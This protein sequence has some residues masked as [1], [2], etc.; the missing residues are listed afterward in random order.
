MASETAPRDS[1]IV[2][3]MT[4]VSGEASRMRRV[5]SIPSIP[6]I[7][8]SMNTT[9]G[10]SSRARSTAS[11]PVPASP[12]TTHGVLRHL[13]R[14]AQPLARDRVVIDDQAR[15]VGMAFSS[16]RG[17]GKYRGDQA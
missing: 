6:G 1:S 4:F 5:A 17:A 7:R 16:V 13:Q 14:G 8:T 3:R 2:M 12:T 11:S 9:S 10:T 15:M